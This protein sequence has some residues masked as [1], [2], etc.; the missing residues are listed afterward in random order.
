MGVSEED[1]HVRVVREPMLTVGVAHS[2]R[3]TDGIGPTAEVQRRGVFRPRRLLDELRAGS[4]TETEASQIFDEAID[5]FHDGA[6][7]EPWWEVLGLS[8][9]QATVLA[10]GG[11]WPEVLA[12]R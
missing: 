7:D 4:I 12:A 10:H 6:Y 9:D 3:Y 11:S 1:L 8:V 2:P 5:A